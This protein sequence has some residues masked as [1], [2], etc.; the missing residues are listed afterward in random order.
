ML[1][2]NRTP[3]TGHRKATFASEWV[4]TPSIHQTTHPHTHTHTPKARITNFFL[5]FGFGRLFVICT[6]IRLLGWLLC[7]CVCK[8]KPT[9]LFFL[10]DIFPIHSRMKRSFHLQI[11]AFHTLFLSLFFVRT[12]DEVCVC[13]CVSLFVRLVSSSLHSIAYRHQHSFYF[14]SFSL[15]IHLHP[16]YSK[17]LSLFSLR[18][19]NSRRIFFGFLEKIFSPELRW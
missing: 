12:A 16:H 1:R 7:V 5:H 19:I 18:V 3:R 9:L 4:H 14:A 17:R 2:L 10:P 15:P 6:S 8:R 11:R 13:V